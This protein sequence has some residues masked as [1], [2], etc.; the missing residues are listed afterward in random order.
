MGHRRVWVNSLG[1]EWLNEIEIGR[2]V[3][4]ATEFYQ[5][6]DIHRTA[7]ASVN[8]FVQNVPRYVFAGD[9][10]AAEYAVQTN[11]V[12]LD[13]GMPFGNSAEVRVGP[14][15]TY[16]KGT[17]TVALPGFPA[18]RQTNAGGRLYARWDNLDNAFFPRR[19]VRANLD[20]FF[21]QRTQSLGSG[22]EEV[23][24]RLARG[25]LVVNAGIPLTR[26]SFLNVAAHAGALNRDDP[27]LVN[28]FLLG[29]LFNLSG[30]R[31]GQLAGSYLGLGR[32]VYYY[33]LT[34]VP[35]VGDV[36]AGGSLETGNTW[37]QRALVSAGD[38]VTAG[39]VFVAADTAL[40]PL[41]FAYGRAT[42]GASSF[43][44]YLGRPR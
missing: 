36:F 18:I 27:S 43:Y 22:A 1:G 2:I 40:G 30:L 7:F 16:Y 9:Q 19:G 37:Q 38:L 13:L 33:R 14:V 3:R 11:S 44:L 17:P 26:D 6:F 35:V 42:G 24:N 15:Y 5:P 31:D 39:S 4:A 21:G 10:P 41:Y 34:R 20:V 23:S 25:D 32:V 29:G 8:G 12:G 28:P